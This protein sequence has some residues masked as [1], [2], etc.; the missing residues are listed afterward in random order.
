MVLLVLLAPCVGGCAPNTL[1]RRLADRGVVYDRC[2]KIVIVGS[3][4]DYGPISVT[5]TASPMS[6]E[7]WDTIIPARPFKIWY[8]SGYRQVRFYTHEDSTEPAAIL[9]VNASGAAHI[10]GDGDGPDWTQEGWYYCPGLG[11]FVMKLLEAEHQR[12]QRLRAVG[13]DG[14]V[15]SP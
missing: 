5:L 11:P 2:P 8:A 9:L 13:P 12:R 7:V 3:E 10:E 14:G 6:Q 4:A 15:P 1:Q